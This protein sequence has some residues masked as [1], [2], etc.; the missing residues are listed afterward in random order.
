MTETTHAPSCYGKEKGCDSSD[1]E[2]AAMALTV[3]GE[4]RRTPKG[5]VLVLPEKRLVEILHCCRQY[6]FRHSGFASC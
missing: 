2:V 5:T 1:Y 3:T 6:M 4:L